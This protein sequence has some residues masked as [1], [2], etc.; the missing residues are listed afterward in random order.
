MA[1]R[2]LDGQTEKFRRAGTLKSTVTETIPEAYFLKRS[3]TG[4]EY[5]SIAADSSAA[6][7]FI[8][9]VGTDRPDCVEG[10]VAVIGGES[11]ELETDAHDST[12]TFV[13][14]EEATVKEVN[15]SVSGI[16]TLAV[17]GD[18]VHGVVTQ[19]PS[20][21]NGNLLRVLM[22]AINLGVKA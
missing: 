7:V 19:V 20:S 8:N 22:A 16:L 6:A 3:G 4:D 11:Y 15:G 2:I 14:D 17:T 21:G 9:L 18:Y 12:C 1:Y 10:G 13:L 5:D